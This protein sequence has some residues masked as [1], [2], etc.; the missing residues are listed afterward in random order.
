MEF[1]HGAGKCGSMVVTT[2]PAKKVA[3]Q[4]AAGLYLHGW[5]LKSLTLTSIWVSSSA[6]ISVCYMVAA[7]AKKAKSAALMPLFS[8]IRVPMAFKRAVFLAR[9][10]SLLSFGGGGAFGHATGLGQAVAIGYGPM[11]YS[12]SVG[13]SVFQ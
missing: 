1:G 3:L 6:K 2:V 5:R 10:Q 9:L 13:V 11:S 8:D 4:T 12:R 7:R